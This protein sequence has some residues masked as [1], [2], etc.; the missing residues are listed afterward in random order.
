MTEGSILNVVADDNPGWYQ[1]EVDGRI[2]YVPKTY[3]E[4]CARPTP[5]AA[6]KPALAKPA[7]PAVAKPALVKPAAT[8]AVATAARPAVAA[9]PIRII[10]DGMCM[11]L[12]AAH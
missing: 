11:C 3:V 4:K 2:G 8:P 10:S 9:A 7:A 1:C 6:A 12:Q 5:P